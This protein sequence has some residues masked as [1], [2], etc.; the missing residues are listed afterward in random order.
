M[1][2]FVFFQNNLTELQFVAAGLRVQ[3]LSRL[4]ICE[5]LQIS[6]HCCHQPTHLDPGLS[7]SYKSIHTH[8]FYP[9]EKLTAECSR[10]HSAHGTSAVRRPAIEENDCFSGQMHACE[11]L[12]LI[13]PRTIR[14]DMREMRDS[15]QLRHHLLRE[16]FQV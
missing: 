5:H 9:T 3:G 16:C 2:F 4:C 6:S 13:H 15:G 10:T 8:I 11:S 12:L 1:C 7:L 14:N